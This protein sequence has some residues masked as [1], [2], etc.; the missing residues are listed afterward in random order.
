MSFHQS[1]APPEKKEDGHYES[2]ETTAEYW[3][4]NG[5]KKAV[6]LEGAEVVPYEEMGKILRGNDKDKEDKEDKEDKQ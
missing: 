1:C 5:Q 4:Y 2:V 6:G 3:Y